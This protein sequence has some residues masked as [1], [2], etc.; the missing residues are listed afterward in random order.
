M[1]PCARIR[2]KKLRSNSL[3]TR[4]LFFLRSRAF[5]VCAF[6]G[7]VP[8]GIWND[9]VDVWFD[10]LCGQFGEYLCFIS[11]VPCAAS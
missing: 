1:C 8:I 4:R 3:T 5:C 11:W 6:C 10:D 9:A 2:K 7:A